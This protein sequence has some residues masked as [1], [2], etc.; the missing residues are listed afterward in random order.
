MI[1]VTHIAVSIST[2]SIISSFFQNSID[3]KTLIIASLFSI[4]P[5][6]DNCRSTI[7]RPLFPLAYLIQKKFGHRGITHSVIF[8]TVL[9]ILGII[10]FRLL[11]IKIWWCFVAY[12]AYLSHLFIDTCTVSGVRLFQP[13][14]NNNFVFPFH[15]V[16]R[17]RTGSIGDFI[18]GATFFLLGF[19]YISL[20]QNVGLAGKI[21]EWAGTT[22][23]VDDQF[24]AFNQ[25]K[26]LAKIEYFNNYTR[27]LEVVEQV[28]LL[29][30]TKEKAYFFDKNKIIKITKPKH[31]IK[32]INIFPTKKKYKTMNWTNSFMPTNNFIAMVGIIG[33]NEI[34]FFS[35]KEVKKYYQEFKK[36]K[37][38]LKKMS[39]TDL[40]FSLE[41]EKEKIFKNYSKIKKVEKK[42]AIADKVDFINKKIKQ[43]K[44][45]QQQDL[46][47]IQTLKNEIENYNFDTVIITE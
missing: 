6:I 28:E 31:T 10:F 3:L 41:K 42:L 47:K 45:T 22:E 17:I 23:L 5:D 34:D 16:N 1:A 27:E 40:I 37:E 30:A 15:S 38:D 36:M 13:I 7:G 19:L 2:T 39:S 20:T 4:L 43:L 26:Y 8:A 25:K 12:W 9:L 35:K 11:E 32:K 21:R 14:F 33:G 29:L 18:I 46:K 24:T 44:K